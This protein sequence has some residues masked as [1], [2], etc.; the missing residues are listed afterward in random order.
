MSG[1][2]G[3]PRAYVIGTVNIWGKVIEHETG[4]R[5]QYIYPKELIARTPT[6][7]ALLEKTYGVPCEVA[8]VHKML[9]DMKRAVME[10]AR[11]L[12]REG[13]LVD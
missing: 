3:K 7:A 9:E 2:F 5:A 13:K 11:A 4:Y 8:D 1:T 10:R 6:V 12:A